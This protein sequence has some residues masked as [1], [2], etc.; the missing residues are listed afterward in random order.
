MFV[1][2]F[3]LMMTKTKMTDKNELM[4]I[5]MMTKTQHIHSAV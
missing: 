1:G 5:M 3:S 4:F 2:V